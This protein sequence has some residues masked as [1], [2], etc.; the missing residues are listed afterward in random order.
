MMQKRKTRY[1]NSCN[2]VI[3]HIFYYRLKIEV[4]M[5]AK[6]VYVYEPRYERWPCLVTSLNKYISK[7][8]SN[9]ILACTETP[10]IVHYFMSTFV[11]I[12]WY[13]PVNDET[14]RPQCD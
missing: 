6:Y 4:K 9:K 3:Y 1:E 12:K 7:L 5:R 8:N 10:V 2:L 11:V 13:H 14:E